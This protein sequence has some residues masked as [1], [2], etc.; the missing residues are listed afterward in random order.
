VA[1]RKT[2]QSNIEL[3]RI[4]AACAVVWLHYNNPTIGGGLSFVSRGSVN[5]FIMFFFETVAISAVNVFVLISGYFLTDNNKRDLLKPIE[6]ILQM[7]ILGLVFCVISVLAMGIE[8][9]TDSFLSFFTPTYWFIF[10]YAALYIFSPYINLVWKK[11]DGAGKKRLLALMFIIFSI[12][13]T[14]LELAKKVSGRSMNGLNPIGLNGSQSGYT[15]VIF[16]FMYLIGCSLRDMDNG[17]YQGKKVESSK[18]I[19]WLVLDVA[20]ILAWTYFDRLVLKKEAY[21]TIAWNYDNPLVI[22]EAVLVFLLFKNMKIGSSRLINTL[23]TA[24]FS[25]YLIHVRLIPFC[26]VEAFSNG[27]PVLL[28]ISLI[29]SAA[30]IYLAS[31]VIFT[32]YN[33]CTKP[34]IAF[35]DKSWKK[36]RKYTV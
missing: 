35:I 14:L 4:L 7:A 12:Y 23:A 11:L 27:N 32:I 1:D 6:L 19:L 28:V 20:V 29:V 25:V 31:F 21:E 2:R 36:G 15:I 9:S 33:L 24:A 17:D 30:G 3:L 18:L 34:L 5:E 8:L 13:P 22:I 10:V 16:V 26:R